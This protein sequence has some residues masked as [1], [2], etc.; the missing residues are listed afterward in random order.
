MRE[1]TRTQAQRS[2]QTQQ[3]VIA[4]GRDLFGTRG[5]RGVAIEEIA[6]VAGV[7]KGALYHHFPDKTEVLAAVYESLEQELFDALVTRVGDETDAI[8]ALN[9]GVEAFLDACLDPV[10]RRIALVEAPSAL[11]WARW[12]DIDSRYGFG[13][14][15]AGLRAAADQGRVSVE[16]ID[17][18]AHLLLAALM[19]ACLLLGASDDLDHTRR[20]VGRT[21]GDLIDGLTRAGSAT[22]AAPGTAAPTAQPTKRK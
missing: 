2:A 14:L 6:R 5:Y 11:G 21:L 3:A 7:S 13:L 12:R 22:H 10:L 4:A 17:D 16:D 1:T 9:V 19:E 15:K 8:V 20:S 18:R